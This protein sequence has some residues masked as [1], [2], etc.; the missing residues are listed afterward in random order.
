MSKGVLF[1]SGPHSQPGAAYGYDG[2]Q[3]IAEVVDGI[4]YYRYGICH[5]ELDDT[6]NSVAIEF[7]ENLEA[8]CSRWKPADRRKKA[9][10]T[11]SCGKADLASLLLRTGRL[12]LMVRT[13][14]VTISD[15]GYVNILDQLFYST[16][17]D[18]D[19]KLLMD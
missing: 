12:P 7:V 2:R 6:E 10:V 4:K 5:D 8:G 17:D 15:M 13:G 19:A 11:I 14:N 1:I 9:D 18:V 3:G 16:E